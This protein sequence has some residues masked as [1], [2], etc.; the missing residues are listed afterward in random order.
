MEVGDSLRRAAFYTVCACLWVLA[1]VV[2]LEGS[3]VLRVALLRGRVEAYFAERNG[4]ARAQEQAKVAEYD[5]HAAPPPDNLS[6]PPSAPPRLKFLDLSDDASRWAFAKERG[7]VIARCDLSGI[8]EAVYHGESPREIVQIAGE[9]RPGSSPV[10]ILPSDKGQD[11]DAARILAGVPEWGTW[12]QYPMLLPDGSSY[13][14]EWYFLP[15]FDKWHSRLG[16]YVFIRES[17]SEPSL[18]KCRPHIFR[19]DTINDWVVWTN[20]LGFRTNE[21]ARPKPSGVFRIVCVGGSTTFEGPRNG[22]TYPALLEKR[23]REYYGTTAIEVYNC[24]IVAMSSSMEKDTFQAFLDFE[25]DLILHY[26]F[27][28]DTATVVNQ[29]YAGLSG[30]EDSAGVIQAW[31]RKSRF[32]SGNFPRALLPG[33]DKFTAVVEATTMQNMRFMAEEAR[34]HGVDMAVCSFAYPDVWHL[35]KMERRVFES[36]FRSSLAIAPEIY[37]YARAVDAYN[38]CVR[39]FCQE[40]GNLYLPVAEGLRE[41]LSCFTDNCHMHLGGIQRKAEVVFAGLKDYLEAKGFSPPAAKP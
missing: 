11:Q 14:A 5:A 38:G 24:G 7:E 1:V 32:L 12:R 8:V 18:C 6:P 19:N 33:E 4:W 31:L 26:N 37:S 36:R 35:P 27:A 2:A 13:F 29:V 30:E 23:L 40:S 34:K 21:V 22:L 39:R 3:E 9:L 28:N 16:T 25:P 15:K 17:F 41:G 20:G 10:V